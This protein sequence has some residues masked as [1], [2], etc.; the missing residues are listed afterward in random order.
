M[1]G[2]PKNMLISWGDMTME[3]EKKVITYV[4]CTDPKVTYRIEDALVTGV[5]TTAVFREKHR[6]G[7]WQDMLNALHRGAAKTKN[8]SV[9]TFLLDAMVDR[10]LEEFHNGEN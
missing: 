7:I 2:Q 8:G 3:K 5:I 6:P 9:N 10:L 4:R 1:T